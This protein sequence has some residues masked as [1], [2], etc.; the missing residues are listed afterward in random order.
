MNENIDIEPSRLGVSVQRTHT[1]AVFVNKLAK[2]AVFL[3]ALTPFLY[4]LWALFTGGLGPN[5]IDSLT[6]Q[7]GTLAI[8]MLLISLAL[9]PLR[10]L[11]K[12]TWP[13]RYRRMLG[14]FAFFYASL[15][16]SVYM[17]LDQQLS[18][19]FILEDLVKR[20]YI[21]AGTTAFLL[22]LPLAITSTRKMVKRL[23]RRWSL[24]HRGVYLASTAAVVHYVW[25]AKGDLLEPFVYLAI[26]MVLFSYRLIKAL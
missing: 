8:R 23:G 1:A 6:D 9:T 13:L 15:H 22:L 2:P 5:P 20:P 4:L 18:L 11:L 14:L 19:H 25:L 10:Y 16:V 26:L 24:L 7:T 12:Q 3:A 21:L 17:V